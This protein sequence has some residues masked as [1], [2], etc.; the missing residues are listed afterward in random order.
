MLEGVS[1]WVCVCLAVQEEGG[2]NDGKEWSC[3]DEPEWGK[4]EAYGGSLARELGGM[5]V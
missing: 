1:L 4:E 5:V 2:A 3:I